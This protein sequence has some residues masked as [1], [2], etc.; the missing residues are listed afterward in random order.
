[1][2]CELISDRILFLL[3]GRSVDMRTRDIAERIGASE[4]DAH[5]ALNRLHAR[6]LVVRRM[7]P[8]WR[9]GRFGPRASIAYWRC[10]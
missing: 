1:M 2:N 10:A 3:N 6:G 7:A 4:T 8:G 9:V 5:G